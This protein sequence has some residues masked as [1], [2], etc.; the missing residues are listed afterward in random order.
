MLIDLET[1]IAVTSAD[2]RI[3]LIGGLALPALLA[4]STLADKVWLIAGDGLL[5]LSGLFDVVTSKEL[6]IL[7]AAGLTIAT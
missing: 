1:Y 7:G 4:S 5:L 3:T 2:E 6:A